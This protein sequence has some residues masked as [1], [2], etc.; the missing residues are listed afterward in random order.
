MAK[1]RVEHAVVRNLQRIKERNS[2]VT[3]KS[4][5]LVTAEHHFVKYPTM[6][7]ICN[8]ATVWKKC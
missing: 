1:D 3:W 7:P 5:Y 4:V 6:T 8:I 2:V